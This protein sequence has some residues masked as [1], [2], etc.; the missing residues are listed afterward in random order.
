M[1]LITLNFVDPIN[2]IQNTNIRFEQHKIHLLMNTTSRKP[3][4][5]PESSFGWYYLN[6]NS[7]E[8]T[9]KKKHT[10]NKQ[11]EDSEHFT[12][13]FLPLHSFISFISFYLSLHSTPKETYRKWI[14]WTNVSLILHM[15]T[16]FRHTKSYRTMLNHTTI[17]KM[18]IMVEYIVCVCRIFGT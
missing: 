14:I 18:S 17:C 8:R 7:Q 6:N 9:K 12:L 11:R 10:E 16:E 1:L 13:A 4:A 15:Y 5:E 3:K 2:C